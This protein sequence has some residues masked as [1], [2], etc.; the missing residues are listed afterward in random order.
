M[1]LGATLLAG[2]GLIKLVAGLTSLAGLRIAWR[3]IAP[4]LEAAARPEPPGALEGS[5][6]PT[7]RGR[8]GELLSAHDIAFRFP[9]RAEPVLRR[10]GFRI[11][12]GDRRLLSGASGSGKSTLVSLLTG[13]RAPDSGI[14]L[15]EGLDRATLGSARWRRRVAAAVQFHENHV[16]TESLAFNLLMGRR[17]PPR[18]SDLA[19]AEAICRRLGLGE[20]IDR[21]PGGLFQLVGETGWQ[22]SHGE[23]SRMFVARALLQGASLVVLDESFAELDP[24]SLRACLHEVAEIAPTL[25]IVAHA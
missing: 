23:R 8:H 22:L 18:G 6:W 4:L 13:L 24:E 11:A 16:F 17:W 25:V 2:G 14:L 20:L 19:L 9:G 7:A 5:R 3:Q 15:L 10:V 1:T 12:Y 21:M